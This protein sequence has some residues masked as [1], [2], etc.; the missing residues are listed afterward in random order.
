MTTI[1]FFVGVTDY[2]NYVLTA[3]TWREALTGI[4]RWEVVLDPRANLW[5]GNF[6]VDATVH[7]QIDGSTQM[8]GY[9]DDILPFMDYRGDISGYDLPRTRHTGRWKLVGRD[10]GMD[11]AQH[12]VTG[13]WQNVSR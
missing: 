8:R 9:I 13:Q 11:L 1:G 5:P 12:Y 6:A 3:D 2:S 7:I 4:G 10:F